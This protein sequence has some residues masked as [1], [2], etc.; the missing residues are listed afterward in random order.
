MESDGLLI[1]NLM[2]I[3]R[4]F[5]LLALVNIACMYWYR[6][7]PKGIFSDHW[8]DIGNLYRMLTAI[9]SPFDQLTN[10]QLYK[11]DCLRVL[12]RVDLQ[13]P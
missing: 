5:A 1:L 4:G 3:E 9:L 2:N 8:F 6:H 7:V 13:A 12:T 11:Y 10:I